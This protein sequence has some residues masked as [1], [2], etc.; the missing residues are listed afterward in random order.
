MLWLPQESKLKQKTETTYKLYNAKIPTG[1]SKQLK[2][3]RQTAQ[4]MTGIFHKSPL[5]VLLHLKVKMDNWSNF[6]CYFDRVEIH[7]IKIHS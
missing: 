6:S 7:R 3:I 1:R 2:L 5:H 4:K